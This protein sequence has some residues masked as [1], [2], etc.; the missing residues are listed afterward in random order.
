MTS[1]SAIK[2]LRKFK[3][4]NQAKYNLLRIALFGSFARNQSDKDSDIDIAVEISEPDIFILSRIKNDL[5]NIFKRKVDLIRLRDK[6]NS[7]LKEN[8]EKD[9]IFV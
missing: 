3:E 1:N 7:C 2:L 5:E 8:I 4:E 9:G 6:M